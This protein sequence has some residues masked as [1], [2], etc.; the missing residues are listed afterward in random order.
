MP[1]YIYQE[2]GWPQFV[3]DSEA[4]LVLLGEVR[5]L[6]GLL[7]GQMQLLGFDVKANALLATLTADVVQSSAIEGEH[8]NPEAVRSS[9]AQKLGLKEGGTAASN[10]HIE[11]VVDM[12]LNA[13]QHFDQPLHERRLCGW[14]AALFPTGFSG[15]YAIEVGRYRSGVMQIVSGPLNRQR[16]HFEAVAPEAVAFEMGRFLLWVNAA[17]EEQKLDP[18]LKAAVA[19]FWF[20]IIHPFDDGNGRIA[21]ALTDMLLARSDGST[22]RF[23]SMSS[24]ILLEKKQY[25]EVLQKVQHSTGEITPWLMWFLNCLKKA[26]QQAA[27]QMQ[28]VLRKSHFWSQYEQVVINERQRLVLNKMLGDFEGKMQSSKWAKMAKCSPDTAL[29]DIKDLVDKGLLQQETAG[30]RSTR[31]EVNY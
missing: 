23:Y 4:V 5:H 12:T 13:T 27:Q 19:H 31:Y 8:L 14:H 9:I 30:G 20:I 1:K 25:Y 22:D 24:Q 28:Q 2:A 21:R 6:Q 17:A 26:L 7:F 3:W 10:R 11:G 29:R 16:V 18:V 15:M